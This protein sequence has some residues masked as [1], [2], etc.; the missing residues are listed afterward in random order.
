MFLV[1]VTND[2][3]T[4]ASDPAALRVVLAPPLITQHPT[5]V[6]ITD[7]ED[8]SFSVVATSVLPLTYQWHRDGVPVASATQ[9]TLTLRP[10]DGDIGA[11][12]SVVVTNT[13]GSITSANASIS[14]IGRPVII[15]HPASLTCYEGDQADFHVEAVPFD[16]V[17][18]LSYQWKRDGVLIP[19][20]TGIR[21]TLTEVA[22]GADQDQLS[23]VVS[24]G[25]AFRESNAATL[26][27]RPR[28]VDR[29]PATV[30]DPTNQTVDPGESAVFNVSVDGAQPIAIQWYRND[31]PIAGATSASYRTPPVLDADYGTQFHVAVSNAYGSATSTAA[32]ISATP[33]IVGRSTIPAADY[34]FITI[35]PVLGEAFSFAVLAKGARPMSYRWYRG[36]VLVPGSSAESHAVPSAALTDDGVVWSVTVSNRA[37]EAT[38]TMPIVR[39]F[40]QPPVIDSEPQDLATMLG[41]DATFA[42]SARGHVRVPLSHQWYR[43]GQPMLGQTGSRLV[44]AGVTAADVAAAFSVVVANRFGS[45]TSRTARLTLDE[46]LRITRQPRPVTASVGAPAV[47]AVVTN[48]PNGVAYHWRKNGQGISRS[49]YTSP[50]HTIEEVTP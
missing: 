27:V 22:L 2:L 43:D 36:G 19:G 8:V 14:R 23:V 16:P 41:R 13:I 45:V 49:P 31:L 47:F 44:L 3:G 26:Y 42:V 29:R 37:G 9:P 18:V 7:D 17:R 32:R 39:V 6:V 48:Q 20:A 25:P 33:V 1:T 28:P 10:T 11:V 5:S 21:L 40:S 24:D 35:S 34:Q 38:T 46:P 15:R 50:S 30:G 12:Y 4:V